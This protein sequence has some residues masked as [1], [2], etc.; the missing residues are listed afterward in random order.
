MFVELISSREISVGS[1][2]VSNHPSSIVLMTTQQRIKKHKL[3][4]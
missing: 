1:A 2:F 3:I 4:Q